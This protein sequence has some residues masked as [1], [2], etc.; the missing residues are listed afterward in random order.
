MKL[1]IIGCTGSVGAPAGPASGYL[2]QPDHAPGVLMD[3]GPGVLAGLQQVTNPSEVHVA[4]THLHADHCLDLPSL[5]VWR[6]YH[7]Q[8]A[9]K[10]RGMLLGPAATVEKL[11]RLTSDAE[12]SVDPMDDIF[13]FTQWTARQA[14]IVDGVSITP[15]PTIHPIESY[16]LRVQESSSGKIIAYSGDSAYTEDLVD[17]ARNADLFLCEATW[18]DT[19]VGKAPDMHMCG[20][21]AGLIASRAGAKKLVLVHIP[22]WADAEAA[23]RSARENFDGE[24][25]IGATGMEIEV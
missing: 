5:T 3:I 7:P 12:G 15:Y 22:P 13:A 10:G 6:R 9:A 24:V 8:L 4:F 25:I 16:G 23:A 1:T 11:G 17:C 14:E 19:S 18:C 21:E 2:V 20:G